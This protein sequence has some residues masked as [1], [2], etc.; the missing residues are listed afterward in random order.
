MRY[1]MPVMLLLSAGCSEAERSATTPAPKAAYVAPSSMTEA[2]A[3]AAATRFCRYF[4]SEPA[5][6]ADHAD[7]LLRFE[8]AG[9]ARASESFFVERMGL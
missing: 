1:L 8:C 5:V 9:R 3:R 7:T 2:E 6:P 4:H